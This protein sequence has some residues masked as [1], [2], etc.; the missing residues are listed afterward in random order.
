M[1]RFYAWIFA[2]ALLSGAASAAPLTCDEI[3]AQLKPGDILFMGLNTKLFRYVARAT[4]TW[5]AHTAFV[6]QDETGKW[7]VYES[8]VPLSTRTELCAFVAR[9]TPGEI[10]A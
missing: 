9:A 7:I 6:L 2:A 1:R 5:V 3:K 8:K 10:A 4:L